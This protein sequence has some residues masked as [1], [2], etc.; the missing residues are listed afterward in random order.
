MMIEF[1]KALIVCAHPDDEVLGVGGTIPLI[2]QKGGKVTV[3][4]VTDGVSSQYP[5]DKEMYEIRHKQ[6]L[7]ACDILGVNDVIHLDF[8]DMSLDTVSQVS[9]NMELGK[10][11]NR[12]QP[13][14]IFTHHNYDVNLDHQI[15]YESVMVIGRPKPQS[16]IKNILT[17][18]VNSSTE[19]GARTPFKMFCPNI[20]I[21]ISSTIDK[22][23]KALE[24]YTHELVP[25]PHPR[26]L[27]AV[28]A[29]AKVLGSE[30][31]ASYAEGFN[32]VFSKG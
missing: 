30:S 28:K 32:L 24:C 3:V 6:L 10:I 9:I 31:G 20:F 27:E 23:L 14:T 12:I 7:S 11:V 13:D 1:N 25:F 26:S 16:P 22:K 15:L 21:D 17:Y 29:R 5:N 18:H 2:I 19:W 4:V 8:P